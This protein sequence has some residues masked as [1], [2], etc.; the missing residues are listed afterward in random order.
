MCE[1][2]SIAGRCAGSRRE[3]CVQT[4]GNALCRKKLA[5][6]SQAWEGR[7]ALGLRLALPWRKGEGC[8]WPA[9][10]GWHDSSVVRENVQKAINK[11]ASKQTGSSPN[12]L[13]MSPAES[14]SCRDPNVDS[15]RGHIAPFWIARLG[16]VHLP[17][18]CMT[19]TREKES[20][21][22]ILRTERR[23]RISYPG[24]GVW[25]T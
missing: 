10:E 5:M 21:L 12:P 23:G 22:I 17:G 7:S 20:P 15:R 11:H 9:R 2:R 6:V 1:G 24:L 18:G 8:R 3:M 16:S 4:R 13:S 14:P 25:N 19:E